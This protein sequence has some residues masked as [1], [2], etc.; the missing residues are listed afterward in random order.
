MLGDGI[1]NRKR[2]VA[3]ASDER[4]ES[5]LTRQSSIRTTPGADIL[6]LRKQQ[7]EEASTHGDGP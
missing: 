2:K 4:E 7:K 5:V 3:Q 6:S 1:V